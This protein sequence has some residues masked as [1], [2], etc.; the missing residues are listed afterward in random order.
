MAAPA[1]TLATTSHAVPGAR[2]APIAP[3]PNT[4]AVTINNLRRP[5]RSA[6]TPPTAAP[7]SEPSKTELTTTSSMAGESEKVLLD[8]QDGA[9]DDADVIAK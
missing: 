2:A 6:R 9:G 1:T 4:N 5:R 7:A 3:T 8:E